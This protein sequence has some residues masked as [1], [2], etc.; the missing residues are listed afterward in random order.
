MG[1]ILAIDYGTKRV[2]LAVT[3]PLQ[4]IATG[5]ETV[6]SAV[7]LDYLEQYFTKEIID[8][9]VVGEPKTLMNK[10]SSNAY[11]VEQ[12]LKKF[13]EKFPEKRV[14]RVDERFT[15]SIAQRTMLDGGLKKSDRKN[16]STVD[17]ISAILIL[18]TWLEMKSR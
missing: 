5:L 4:L 7:L 2:G 11:H 3:D 8:C 1:R 18:Q 10:A 13:R 17:V 12:F 9:V 14:E 16:K 15:S 6:S